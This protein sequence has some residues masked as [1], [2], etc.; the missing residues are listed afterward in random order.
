M[1][2]CQTAIP[3]DLTLAK[4]GFL[5]Q[6]V[7]D[8]SAVRNFS[9]CSYAFI[10]EDGRFKFDPSYVKSSNFIELYGDGVPLVLD[11]V[12]GDATCVQAKNMGSFYN[13]LCIFPFTADR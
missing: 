8:N 12:V 9:Q 4:T 13:S 1:G 11:W 2:C 5:N 7:V 6:S 3:G 10:V